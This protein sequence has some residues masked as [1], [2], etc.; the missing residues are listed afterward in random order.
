MMT[1]L[2]EKM[3][4]CQHAVSG[5]R[6]SALTALKAALA[7]ADWRVRYAAVVAAGDMRAGVLVPAL[8]EVLRQEDAAPLYSQDGEIAGGPA[9]ANTPMK[10]RSE[11]IDEATLDAWRR[12]GRLKQAVLWA[13]NDIGQSTPG[14]RAS[15]H[16][17][18]VD[19][20]EDYAVRAAACRALRVLGNASS[21]A[22]L[23][24]AA[25]DD[26]WCTNCEAKK[27]LRVLKKSP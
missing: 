1:T 6:E 15:L 22:V 17:Y 18:A 3:E 27:S 26:E 12:R 10:A 14:I 25:K 20:R 2:Y 5:D 9:G 7:D 8:V 4:A 16:K 13:L 21:V 19:Q 23:E 24:Q 11:G